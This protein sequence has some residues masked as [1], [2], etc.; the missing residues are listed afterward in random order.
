MHFTRLVH[1]QAAR[2]T[3]EEVTKYY[4]ECSAKIAVILHLVKFSGS[5]SC[6]N[7]HCWP[8]CKSLGTASRKVLE[9]RD[10]IQPPYLNK[11][12]ENSDDSGDSEECDIYETFRFD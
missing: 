10:N 6:L 1:F 4:V 11:K 7:H 3:S 2:K 5:K 8:I 12:P 9:P